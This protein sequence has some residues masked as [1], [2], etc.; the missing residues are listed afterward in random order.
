MDTQN[1]ILPYYTTGSLTLATGTGATAVKNVTIRL[2][3][4]W[5]TI[6]TYTYTEDPTPAAQTADGAG[7][8]ERPI[9]REFWSNIYRY[10]TVL[11]SHYRVRFWTNDS[12]D[13][14]ADIWCYH[15]GQQCPPFV[16]TEGTP[17]VIYS[18]YR[19]LHRHAHYKSIRSYNTSATEKGLF[20][21]DIV[22]TGEYRQGNK[23]V[24]NDVAEDEYK[25]TWHR[26]TEVPS[27]HEMATFIL[28]R[29]ERSATAS[30][31]LLNYDIELVFHVQ[32][33]DLE[34]KFQYLEPGADEVFTNLAAQVTD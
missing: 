6:T 29:S 15:H 23:T 1:T 32:W 25:E 33:K 34:A 30:T 28:Q 3:S 20:S 17:G 18:K 24:V 31:F 22:F 12:N 2:N 5:D 13:Q 19:K 8:R 16:T 10:W 7:S 26:T 14:E 4:I 9:M 11:S 21:R 27:M